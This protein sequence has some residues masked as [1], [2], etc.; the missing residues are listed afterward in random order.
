[1]SDTELDPS[2]TSDGPKSDEGIKQ[3]QVLIELNRRKRASKRDTTKTRYHL[4]KLIVENVSGNVQ[5]LE[6]RIETLW[7]VL[8]ETQRIMD[9]LSIYFMEQMDVESQKAVMQ[10]SKELEAE[11]EKIIEKAQSV[12]V[13][14]A[15]ES[16]VVS[17]PIEQNTTNLVD[18]ADT[19][20]VTNNQGSSTSTV[21]GIGI[22]PSISDDIIQGPQATDNANLNSDESAQQPINEHTESISMANPSP[23]QSAASSSGN[24][25]TVV[26]HRLKLLKVP[27]F[28]GDKKKFEEFWGLFESL[29]DK[30]NEPTS[31]KMARL[32]QSLTGIAL[33]S[34][35]GLGVSEPEYKEAKEILNT[36][37][38]G[39]RRQLRAY[40]DDLERMH[41]L[42]AADVKGF[43]S[44]TDLVRVTVVKL[45]AEGKVGE[46]GDGTLYSLLVKKLTGHQLEAYTRWMNE[47]SKE[48]SVLSL[49]D[50]LNG[51]ESEESERTS[52]KHYPTKGGG[53][54]NPSSFFMASGNQRDSPFDRDNGP[55]QKPPC[56][57]C[58]GLHHGIWACRQFEQ[59][60]VEERWN[61]AKE[62]HLCFRCLNKDHRGK[63]C[64]RSQ[65]CKVNGCQLNHH[66]LLHRQ[67]A[68]RE[69]TDSREGADS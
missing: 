69:G 54:S 57:F 61:F 38:G 60:S 24:G 5:E 17:P 7:G 14:W 33:D 35:R 42:R 27:T 40:L 32:R 21:A 18:K 62:K 20:V 25:T 46:P 47:H 65:P 41:P 9:E 56:S 13:K 45:Q 8:E 43:A 63:E 3:K 44:F 12:I 2:G 29:V 30:S 52:R 50:W 58:N 51:I 49:R 36:K 10:E 55:K 4:E 28:N 22:N 67:T 64:R 68:P 26:N 66:R 31:L 48:R 1:M 11:C 37:F 16:N 53:R 39:Q 23:Q 59:R 15:A 19:V 6:H 34:I